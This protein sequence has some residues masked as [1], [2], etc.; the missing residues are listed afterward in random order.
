MTVKSTFDALPNPTANDTLAAV[1]HHTQHSAVNDMIRAFVA[2]AVPLS[3]FG[4]VGDLTTDDTAA[5]QAFFDAGE[6]GMTLLGTPG[7]YRITS[8]ITYRPHTRYLGM[9]AEFV[10]DFTTSAYVD[11]L[12]V[13]EGYSTATRV[14]DVHFHDLWLTESAGINHSV[15]FTGV[16]LKDSSLVGLR[17][18]KTSGG[19]AVAIAG[20]DLRIE[21]ADIRVEANGNLFGDGIHVVQGHRILITKSIIVSDS[22]DAISINTPR[23][24]NS[25]VGDFS[26]MSDIQISDCYL[27]GGA[28]SVRIGVDAEAGVNAVDW[29]WG[30]VTVSDCLLPDGITLRDQ[31]A[32]VTAPGGPVIFRGCVIGNDVAVVSGQTDGKARWS[33]LTFDDCELYDATGRAINMTASE[34]AVGVLTIKGGNSRAPLVLAAR[35]RIDIADFD[36]TTSTTETCAVLSAP[37]I[38]WDGGR[39]TGSGTEY[40]G[41]ALTD[42]SG[43]VDRALINATIRNV[44]RGLLTSDATVTVLDGRCR[45]IDCSTS[46]N[47]VSPTNGGILE[48]YEPKT[49]TP[50]LTFA[51]AGDLSVAYS[52]LVGRY[53]KI[54]RVVIVSGELVTSAF[55]HSTASGQ[56]LITGLPYAAGQRAIG[57][58]VMAG[59][60]RS[61]AAWVSCNVNTAASQLNFPVSRSGLDILAS[62]EAA[63]LPSAG[64]VSIRFAITYT[65]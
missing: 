47:G 65:V 35:D 62:L 54:G 63:D 30:A 29:T 61:D 42:T 11:A 44:A 27:S 48:G 49:W 21:G 46:G 17:I 50:A 12:F 58:V 8:P 13:N 40:G 36:V 3:A 1:P 15:M 33:R 56:L 53:T 43:T 59:W 22:D 64:T 7:T 19:W 14:E 39:V 38:T 5:V 52:T 2:T 57:Q 25:V 4:A 45:F 24:D 23:A 10:K 26:G 55:T 51:T 9:G 6:E 28:K 18:R 20:D 32:E 60:T 31:R 41:I 16:T 34:D 37:D